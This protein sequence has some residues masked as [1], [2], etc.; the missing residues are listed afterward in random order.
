MCI[1]TLNN[2]DKD[3]QNNQSS[4]VAVLIPYLEYNHAKNYNDYLGRLIID[5]Q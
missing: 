3:M 2:I 5:P 1:F 4:T